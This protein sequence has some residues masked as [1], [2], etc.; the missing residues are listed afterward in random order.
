LLPAGPRRHFAAGK[1]QRSRLWHGSLPRYSVCCFRPILPKRYRFKTEFSLKP[2]ETTMQY[3]TITLELLKHYRSLYDRLLKERTFLTTL[4]FY[5]GELRETHLVWKERLWQANP[6]SSHSLIAS[7]ALEIALNEL[8]G[9]LACESPPQEDEELS[10][11]GAMAFILGHR[12]R[13]A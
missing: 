1:P 9:R 7:E 5:A 6:S 12:T 11:D 13:A 10:L 3:K 8:Q 2:K 4:N